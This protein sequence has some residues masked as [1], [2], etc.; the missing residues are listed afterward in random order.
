MVSVDEDHWGVGLV[1]STNESSNDTGGK[2]LTVRSFCR[3]NIGGTKR[4]D[5]YGK[6]ESRNSPIR[7]EI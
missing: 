1:H 4:Q 2:G 7:R 5:V 3:Q 6:R